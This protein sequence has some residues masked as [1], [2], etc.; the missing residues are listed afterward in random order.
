MQLLVLYQI[1]DRFFSFLSYDMN[2]I[3]K[4]LDLG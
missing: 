3:F 2:D 4:K 1:K